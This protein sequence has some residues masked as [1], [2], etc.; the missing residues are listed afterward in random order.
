MRV[1]HG[2]DLHEVCYHE[3][4]MH[5]FVHCAEL[6]LPFSLGITRV[7]SNEDPN[8]RTVQILRFAEIDEK[9]LRATVDE[10]CDSSMQLG[11]FLFR[12]ERP[13]HFDQADVIRQC[14]RCYWHSILCIGLRSARPVGSSTHRRSKMKS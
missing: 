2:K 5:M 3:D 8:R 13:F 6:E 10:F 1:I 11:C 12:E 7:G 14:D 9:S 4:D